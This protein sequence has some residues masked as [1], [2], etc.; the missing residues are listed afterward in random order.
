M[1]LNAKRTVFQ[2]RHVPTG[3]YWTGGW[4]KYSTKTLLDSIF[5]KNGRL[6]Q[7]KSGLNNALNHLYSNEYLSNELK[8][9]LHECEIV[10]FGLELKEVTK[11]SQKTLLVH[12]E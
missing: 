1:K 5:A 12:K 7:G 6:F 2:L 9:L 10:E 8:K 11:F 3:M 4:Y